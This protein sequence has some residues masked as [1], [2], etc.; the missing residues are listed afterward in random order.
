MNEDRAAKRLAH[1]AARD[2]RIAARRQRT[3]G[4]QP[5]APAADPAPAEAPTT[6]APAATDAMPLP[7]P[8]LVGRVAGSDN[9]T[10]FD[11]SGALT[12]GDWKR[13]LRAIDRQFED[14]P[15]I[16]DFGCGCGRVLRHL[17][18]A[19]RP[20]QELIGVDVDAEAIGWV[21][22][23]LPG[24]SAHVQG[25]LPPSPIADEAIDL[26]VNQSVFTHLPED[27]GRAWLADLR[28]MLKPGGIAVLSFHGRSVWREFRE[29]M[30]TEGSPEADLLHA[31]SGF[32]RNGFFYRAG[33]NPFEGALPEYY[34]TAIHTIDYVDTEWQR[35][36][37]LLAW[38]PRG[39]LQHQ[40]IVVLR[41]N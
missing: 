32:H 33:R 9:L 8:A 14:F 36:L 41:K 34:G 5:A 18:G 25:Q 15:R 28:R 29:A 1:I 2:A 40:D 27:V 37:E 30:R 17:R 39:S 6:A 26:I 12:V 11:Q 35:Y 3:G 4:V 7:P 22:A 23:N 20:D 21:N 10:W 24:V 38:L 19:L 31:D 16:L 13:A